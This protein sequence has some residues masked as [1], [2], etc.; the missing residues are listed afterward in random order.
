VQSI[1]AKDFPMVQGVVLLSAISYMV[2]N[3]LVDIGY[4]VLDPR[5]SYG[6]R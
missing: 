5:V 6:T 2:V 3:L 1:L 4:G